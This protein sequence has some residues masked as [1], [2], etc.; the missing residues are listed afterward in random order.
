MKSESTVDVLLWDGGF[1]G[2]ISIKVRGG[3]LIPHTHPT[4]RDDKTES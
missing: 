3:L 1:L 4:K 2:H